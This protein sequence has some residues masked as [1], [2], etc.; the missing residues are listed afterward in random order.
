M[1]EGNTKGTPDGS[2]AWNALAQVVSDA[3]TH[4]VNGTTTPGANGLSI[5]YPRSL[6]NSEL[7]KCPHKA[8][9][10]VCKSDIARFLANIMQRIPKSYMS[11]P[12]HH[13]ENC[14]AVLIMCSLFC[15]PA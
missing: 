6:S 5:L 12:S 8:I 15:V 14:A 9:R 13:V 7:E 1:A 2:V 4:K 11:Q 3:V 10:K